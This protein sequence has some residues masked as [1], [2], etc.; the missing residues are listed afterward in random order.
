MLAG[1]VDVRLPDKVLEGAR[2]ALGLVAAVEVDRAPV[3]AVG[4]PA[5]E[6]DTELVIEPSCLVGDID[7]DLNALMLPL[8]GVG[9]AA[10]L[11]LL[12][13]LIAARPAPCIPTALVF[14]VAVPLLWA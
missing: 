13:P 8:E 1:T 10:I 4:V 7:G 2:L 9:D 14:A 3:V 6:V 11:S 12:C 5:R